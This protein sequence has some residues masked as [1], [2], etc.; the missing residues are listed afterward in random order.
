M[1]PPPANPKLYHIVH[2]DKLPSIVNDGKLVCDA[3]MAARADAGTVIGMTSIKDRRLRLPVKCQPGLHVGE[4][5][6]FYFC[7]RSVMLYLIY[8]ANHPELTY[9]GGQGPIV[10]LQ[11]D[12]RKVAAWADAQG[13]RWAFTLSNAGSLYF[14][15]RRNLGELNEI[16][17]DAVNARMWAKGYKEG[18]QA[19]FLV[20]QEVPWDLVEKIGVLSQGIA[21]RVGAALAGASNNP[22][23]EIKN[24]WY[25]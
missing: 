22:T 3:T 19:E 11:F 8:Q 1:T 13:L 4:C 18:K 9:K 20:E 25:Y 7:P 23:I 6:P 10:H 24:D 5:V 14:E 16:E 17:W 21:Q 2:V 15:D 12:L